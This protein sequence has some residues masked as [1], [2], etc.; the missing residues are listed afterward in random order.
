MQD[1]ITQKLSELRQEFDNGT[2]QLAK[3]EARVAELRKVLL[4]IS[5]A[6]QVLEEL[7]GATANSVVTAKERAD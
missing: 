4:R 3:L 1:I 5:G 6:I 2:Q 7:P